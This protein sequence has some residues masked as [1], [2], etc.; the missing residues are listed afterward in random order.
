MPEV[1]QGFSLVGTI[2]DAA[3]ALV[4]VVC[5]IGYEMAVHGLAVSAVI[6][7]IALVQYACHVKYA[8]PLYVVSRKLAIFCLILAIPGGLSLLID[9]Y[10]PAVNSL[11][12]N[13]VGILC[14]WG[15]VVSHLC[16]EEMNFQWFNEEEPVNEPSPEEPDSA[17]IS[18]TE[19]NS[20]ADTVV[21]KEPVVAAGK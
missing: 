16:M 3:H 2:Q 13:S 15:L 7:A 10:L 18:Q 14:F 11:Q 5:R 8:H 12:L 6:L 17:I 9:G 21:E 20:P 1:S 19:S 4:A